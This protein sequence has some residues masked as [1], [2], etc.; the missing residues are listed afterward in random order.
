MKQEKKVALLIV[1]V[2][3]VIHFSLLF[4]FCIPDGVLNEKTKGIASAYANPL[5][6]GR[7]NLFAPDPPKRHKEIIYRYN[8]SEW[9]RVVDEIERKHNA[10]RIGSSTKMYHV[11]QNASHYLW[12]DYYKYSS[13]SIRE[14][15]GYLGMKHLLNK[16]IE[17]EIKTPPYGSCEMALLIEHI[18]KEE[19]KAT[20]TDTL[21][22]PPFEI[23]QPY[24]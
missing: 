13:D 9:K 16:Y 18:V 21:H 22:F 3:I 23:I 7:W 24:H 4:L 2:I 14:S 1:K 10:V 12:E 17:S 19:G 5:F 8:G 6:Q 11:I 20:I 15:V